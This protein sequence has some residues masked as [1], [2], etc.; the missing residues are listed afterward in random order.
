MVR[1]H[2]ADHRE[3]P[4]DLPPADQMSA[5]AWL[6]GHGKILIHRARYSLVPGTVPTADADASDFYLLDAASGELSK[7]AG[8][9]RPLFHETSRQL[10]PTSRP[11][12][13]WAAIPLDQLGTPAT[14]VG[15]Y[16]TSEF[17]FQPALTVLGLSFS[18]LEMWVDE[19]ARHV[20]FLVN[21][22]VLRLALP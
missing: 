14:V 18:S 3:F 17:T 1:I 5:L 21:G 7:V 9:F 2:V 8:E 19:A 11:T 22:D 15:R 10:Q 20:T 12:E 6:S 4:V 13:F 16:N